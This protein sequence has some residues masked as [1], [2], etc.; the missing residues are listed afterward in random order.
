M[1]LSRARLNSLLF[2]FMQLKGLQAKPPGDLRYDIAF[3]YIRWLL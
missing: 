3:N 2:R 1:F